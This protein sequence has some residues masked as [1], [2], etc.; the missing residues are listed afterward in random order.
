VLRVFAVFWNFI[1]RPI[2]TL[3]VMAVACVLMALA[4]EH[5]SEQPMLACILALLALPIAL[6]RRGGASARREAYLASQIRNIETPG[7]VYILTNPDLPGCVKIGMTTG[8]VHRR[9]ENV[10]RDYRL[11]GKVRRAFVV[12][13]LVRTHTP[14]GLE[15]AM[16][17]VF[18]N[19]NIDQGAMEGG[20]ELFYVP[21]D[22][23]CAMLDHLSAAVEGDIATPE[24][25]AA[26]PRISLAG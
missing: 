25:R 3:A 13:K 18:S 24:R 17:G 9:A 15:K 19:R 6:S 4:L 16:H 26:K 7:S 14:R 23:A 21:L 12:R 1:V 11:R 2:M 8:S 5:L 10:S 22:E 20:R